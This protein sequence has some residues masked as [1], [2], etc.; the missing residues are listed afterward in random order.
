MVCGRREIDI[1][2]LRRNTQYRHGI[3]ADDEHIKR[4]WR[5]L[6]SFSHEQRQKF[7]RFVWGQ[8]RLPH[9]DAAF[10]RPFEVLR[11]FPPG[12]P[13]TA[14]DRDTDADAFA[15][16][17]R[18]HDAAL[19]VSHTCFF[20]MELPNYSSDETMRE[21]LLYAVHNCQAIDTDF[22][23]DNVDWEH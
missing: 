8:S 3:H 2:L 6:T 16:F 21:K 18:A 23:A 12:V 20:S 1:G 10:E 22:A 11:Y 17:Q 15:A 5:V 13:A 7:L 4:F 19:P 14:P 9:D